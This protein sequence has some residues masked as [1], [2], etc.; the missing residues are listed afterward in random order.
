MPDGKPTIIS[1]Y[2][3]SSTSIRIQW[4]PPPDH[5]IHGEFLGYRITYRPRDRPKEEKDIPIR[6]PSTRVSDI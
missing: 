6:D 3:T 4:A 1:A 5:T 2:N